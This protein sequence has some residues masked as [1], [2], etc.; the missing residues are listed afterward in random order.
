[1]ATAIIDLVVIH[2][3]GTWRASEVFQQRLAK[4]RPLLEAFE[5]RTMDLVAGSS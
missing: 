4:I 3:A 1:L 2:T 5:P